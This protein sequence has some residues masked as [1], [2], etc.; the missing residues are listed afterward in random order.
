MLDLQ[1]RL[2]SCQAGSAAL[3]V[4]ILDNGVVTPLVTHY[5]NTNQYIWSQ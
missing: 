4:A 1:E 3:Q 5:N 2:V